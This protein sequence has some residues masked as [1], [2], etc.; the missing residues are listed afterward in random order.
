MSPEVFLRPPEQVFERFWKKFW[1]IFFDIFS[2]I[3]WMILVNEKLYKKN[4]L[5]TYVIMSPEVFL[6]PLEHVFAA[7]EGENTLIQ[8]GALSTRQT[9]Y[10]V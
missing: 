7:Q 9:F 4:F 1:T 10:V 5:A 2:E 8:I 6:K 3:F